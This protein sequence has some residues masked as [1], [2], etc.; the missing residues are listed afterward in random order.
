MSI[1]NIF[2]CRLTG[3]ANDLEWIREGH[4]NYPLIARAPPYSAL[5]ILAEHASKASLAENSSLPEPC[6]TRRTQTLD[7]EIPGK[8]IITDDPTLPPPSPSVFGINRKELKKT[9]EMSTMQQNL[10]KKHYSMLK[11][12][13]PPNLKIQ[14]LY[15]TLNTKRPR[16]SL[17]K[18]SSKIKKL[19]PSSSR[20]QQM[21][22]P[23]DQKQFDNAELHK[24]LTSK[25]MPPPMSPMKSPTSQYQPI[26]PATSKQRG[27][28]QTIEPQ[29]HYL[30]NNPSRLKSELL[31]GMTSPNKK[32]VKN[33]TNIQPK[34]HFQ[35][36]KFANG[37]GAR[38]MDHIPD[39]Q[40]IFNTSSSSPSSSVNKVEN[41]VHIE[42]H[43]QHD[44]DTQ[45][46]PL[47]L[48]STAASCTPK[49]KV[50][51]ATVNQQQSQQQQYQAIK[52]NVSN[53][54]IK[55]IPA[56]SKPV[57]IKSTEIVSKST[58]QLQTTN[59]Q[60]Q[61]QSKIKIQKFQLMMN[62]SQDGIHMTSQ[63]SNLS[64]TATIVS[65][66]PGQLVLS[67]K[68]ITS[69][70]QVGKSPYAINAIVTTPKTTTLTTTKV[71]DN[72]NDTNVVTTNSNSNFPKVIIKSSPA[73]TTAIPSQGK[74]IKLKLGTNIVNTK[75]LTAP[76]TSFKIQRNVN[77]KGFTVL[78][79][80]HIVQIQQQQQSL[81]STQI[82]IIPTTTTNIIT[83]TITTTTE[84]TKV[85][86]EQELDDVN[87]VKGGKSQSN[88]SD[89]PI[90][91]KI[92]LDEMTMDE[93]PKEENV[94]VETTVDDI[95]E[96]DVTQ[97]T[98]QIVAF[99]G[100]KK[101]FILTASLFDY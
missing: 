28:I 83:P 44:L 14:H 52:T 6:D 58:Q 62:R 92:K 61:Q 3:K 30:P 98:N 72:Q 32:R 34:N 38:P 31:A 12:P 35:Q 91:K 46:S 49:L 90:A 71:E 11:P 27:N 29:T 69:S 96:E 4:R 42:H 21:H 2:Y 22:S 25:L 65:S 100:K 78:N 43:N 10:R 5:H 45:A 15:Q 56:N 37:A 9:Y 36:Q 79:P 87:R 23:A 8:Q 84:S 50:N 73:T 95:I 18:K 17:T 81:S 68:S 1:N 47:Q 82:A 59:P 80:S 41:E 16:K 99:D 74:Q 57:V 20:A 67:G 24:H 51:S 7:H 54:A 64:P 85:D 53:R 63:P 89:G 94:I 39:P 48:L 26:L 60:Q 77:T 40:I 55:I 19:S 66:K 75:I 86:W 93:N 88:G 101:S 97:S 13:P 70:Y 33:I 76:L